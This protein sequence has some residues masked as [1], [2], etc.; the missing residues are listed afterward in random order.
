M[1]LVSAE[2]EQ[3]GDD[4]SQY[5]Q[6]LPDSARWTCTFCGF[7]KDLY[8]VKR[9]VICVHLK[10]EFKCQYCGRTFAQ[11]DKRQN[12]L[13]HDHS[14]SLKMKDIR[15]MAMEAGLPR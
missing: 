11:E 1:L 8:S 6:R 3:L 13:K 5:V 14:L 12:H 2:D 15:T 9:H 7:N 4:P 10:L